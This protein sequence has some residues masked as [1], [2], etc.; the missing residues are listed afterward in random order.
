MI[1][2][3]AISVVLASLV[4]LVFI[5]FVTRH[6]RAVITATVEE[7]VATGKPTTMPR[8]AMTLDEALRKGDVEAVKQHMYWCL[9]EH[10]CDLDKDLRLAAAAKN[11]AIAEVLIAAGAKVNKG[12]GAEGTPLHSA[13]T[14]GR[15]KTAEVLLHAGA[16]TNARDEEGRTPLHEAAAWGHVELA[17]VLI[18]AGADVNATDKGG[19]TALHLVASRPVPPLAVYADVARMLLS[20]GA[21]PNARATDGST[22]LH[23]ALA[24]ASRLSLDGNVRATADANE[25]VSVIRERGGRE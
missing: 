17:R 16:D 6:P 11:P 7:A 10:R 5:Y 23:V 22:P 1:S 19:Q 24:A 21:R 3:F 18:Q 15:T 9:R 2:V 13:A 14:V 12:A 4:N 20:A 8:P 25:V